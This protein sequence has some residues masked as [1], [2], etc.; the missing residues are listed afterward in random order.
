MINRFNFITLGILLIAAFIGYRILMVIFNSGESQSSRSTD[1]NA[2]TISQKEYPQAPDFS[3]YDLEGNMIKLSDH[4]GKVVIID[5]W[6]TWCGPCRVGIPEFIE[7]Q[8]RFGKEKLTVLGISVDH[9]D[10]SL[11]AAFAKVYKINYP[12]LYFTPEVIEA[13][14]GIQGIPTTFIIDREGKVREKLIGYH[15]KEYF[16]QTVNRLL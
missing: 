6:A 15:Q 3:L 9:G 8:N 16:I 5:F 12:V 14:G 7:I 1:V 4:K 10:K 2:E 13:Y 11:V